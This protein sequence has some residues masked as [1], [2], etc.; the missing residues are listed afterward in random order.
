MRYALPLLLAA[1]AFAVPARAEDAKSAAGDAIS[2]KTPCALKNTGA[3]FLGA[4][5]LGAVVVFAAYSSAT[6]DPATTCG[7]AAR[8]ASIRRCAICCAWPI[9]ERPPR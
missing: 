5:F 4:E 7:C 1:T 2:V 3:L 9:V 6:G 8:T